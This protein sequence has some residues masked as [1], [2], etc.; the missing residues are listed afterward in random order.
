MRNRSPIVPVAACVAVFVASCQ[1]TAGTP[2]S[3]AWV[4]AGGLAGHTE[5]VLEVAV[6]PDGRLL[7]SASLDDTVRIWDL[8]TAR[9]LRVLQHPD[10]VYSVAFHPTL[11]LVASACKDSVVRL[12]N[13]EG[14][15][16]LLLTGNALA[17][18]SVAFSPDGKRVA[19]AGED[20]S[21]RIW[22]VDTGEVTQ[23]LSGH[24]DKV[25]DV[26]FSPDGTFMAT[27][28]S[29]HTVRL[30]RGADGVL[31]KVLRTP[32]VTMQPAEMTVSFSPDSQTLLSAGGK[33]ATG[34]PPVVRVWSVSSLRQAATLSGQQREIWD[35]RYLRSGEYIAGAGRD[36]KVYFWRAQT[37]TLVTSLDVRAG[38]LWSVAQSLDGNTLYVA[39]TSRGIQIYTRG[40]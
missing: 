23:V 39:T 40:G 14:G 15:D 24:K 12:W 6:S 32:N 9:E 26:A 29:D 20:L 4:P 17:V 18:Y 19:S 34:E 16:P 3:L 27:A 11:P 38:P 21:V 1:T 35:V 2:P 36:G 8:A 33:P 7:A 13:L 30:W 5:A 37:G 31:V 22:D 10:D 25:H 28:S